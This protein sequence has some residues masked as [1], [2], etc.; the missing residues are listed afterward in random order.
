MSVLEDD[1]LCL[2]G[3]SGIL[4]HEIERF[5][6]FGLLAFCKRF[7]GFCLIGF[8]GHGIELEKPILA[9]FGKVGKM[10]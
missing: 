4:E 6:G 7:D 3:D 9:G 1:G 10:F 5:L 8:E 2:R